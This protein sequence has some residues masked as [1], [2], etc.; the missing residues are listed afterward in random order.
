VR[1]VLIGQGYARPGD[2]IVMTGGHPI[3]TRGATNFVKVTR[4]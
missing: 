1:N 3:A 2:Q 4:L